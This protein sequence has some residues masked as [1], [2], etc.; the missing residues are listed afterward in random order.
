MS[1]YPL[2]VREWV[3]KELGEPVTFIWLYLPEAE[4]LKRLLAKLDRY[5]AGMESTREEFWEK[6]DLAK[7]F[8]PCSQEAVERYYLSPEG[9]G[10]VLRGF[11]PFGQDEPLSFKIDTSSAHAQ[12]VPEV[13]RI[14]N[15]PVSPEEAKAACL[16]DQA[17]EIDRISLDR[18][19]A[20]KV[21]KEE[22]EEKA[23]AKAVAA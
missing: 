18:F 16:G 15:L 5:L 23:A 9:G 2:V 7:T 3:R 4:F 13:A 10:R 12:V 19:A 1:L 6:R 11:E 17:A 20:Y 22:E 14:L 21:R 8:G